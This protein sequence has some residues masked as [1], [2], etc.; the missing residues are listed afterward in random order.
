MDLLIKCFLISN[1]NLFK[2][3]YYILFA[4]ALFIL[5]LFF[6]S[7][8][9]KSESYR[10]KYTDSYLN[11]LLRDLHPTRT[12]TTVEQENFTTTKGKYLSQYLREEL[13]NVF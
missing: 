8:S 3:K 9:S 12:P 10:N 11:N 1:K 13:Q 2:V 7:K 4:S 5:V 6:D